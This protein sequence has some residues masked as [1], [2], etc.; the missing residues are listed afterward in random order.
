[1]RPKGRGI[2]VA[3]GTAQDSTT[4]AQSE[5]IT[6]EAAVLLDV[7]NLRGID[8]LE[9][10]LALLDSQGID[11]HDAADEIGTGFTVLDDKNKL[12]G[13]PFLILAFDFHDSDKKREDGQLAK[14][15]SMTIVTKAPILVGEELFRK[16]IVNDGGT[17][18]Y[19]QLDEWAVK[20]NK[21]GGLLVRRGLRASNYDHPAY[22]ESTTHYLAV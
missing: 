10:A 2:F 18:I 3:K 17:G 4:V 16:F 19:A 8:S 21:R 14:F 7:T 20:A 12:I 15:V 13:V 9:D 11:I 6:D 1:M 22:G 5:T